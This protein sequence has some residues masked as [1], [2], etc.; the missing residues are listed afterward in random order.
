MKERSVLCETPAEELANTIS[1]A[2]GAL[3]SLIGL[4]VMLKLAVPL[5]GWHVVGVSVFGSSLVLLYGASTLYHLATSHEKKRLLQ[6]LDH[7]LIFVLIAGSYTPWLLVSLRGPWGW[8]LLAAVWG[9]ALGGV[10]LKT[11][12]LPRFNRLGT[13]LYILMGWMICIAIQPLMEAVNGVGMAWLV[14]GGLC[15]TGGVFF[16]LK[17]K[18]RYGHFI[19]HLFVLAGSACHCIAVIFGVLVG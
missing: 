5:S 7:A 17:P 11:I 19:W 10:I 8:S 4:G 1:H 2:V 9:L 18:L 15:Y 3:L 13:A 12:L 16:Y 14:A 6:I